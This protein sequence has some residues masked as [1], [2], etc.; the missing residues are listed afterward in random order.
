MSLTYTEIQKFLKEMELR[1]YPKL[2]IS[3]LRNITIEPI[4]P[5]LQ[6]LSYNMGYEAAI[7]FGDYDTV[8]NDAVG[9]NIQLLNNS[10]DCVLIFVKLEVLSSLLTYS[11]PSL[12]SEQIESEIT[13]IEGYINAVLKG[14]RQQTNAMI[15]WMGFDLPVNPALGIFDSQNDKGQSGTIHRLNGLVQKN[16]QC[17]E[18]TYFVD[19]NLS[20]ARIG[21]RKYFDHRYWHIGRAPFTKDALEDI[22]NESFKFIRALKGKSKKCLVVD[23]D[24]TLWA[25]VIGE[26]NLAGIKLSKSSHPGSSFYEFQ[27]EIVNLYHR[28]ILVA[29]CSKNNESDVW[30]VFNNHPD[31][32]LHPSHIATAQ[33]N[34]NDKASNIRQ[35]AKDLNIG[36][37]SLVFMD[38][39]EF[40]I[41][42]VRQLLPEVECVH[43]PASKS[44]SYRSILTSGGWFDNLLFTQED[45]N[46]GAMYKT[47]QQRSAA[48]LDFQSI[49]EYHQSLEMVVEINFA[50]SLSIPRIAQ[51]TQKTNQFNIT[52]KRYSDADIL[53][54]TKR[55]NADAVFLKLADKFGD[56]GIVGVCI[57]AYDD[58]KVTIDTF[59]L[60]CRVLGRKVENAFIL[61]I[62][63]LAKFRGCEIV[64]GEYLPT[65]KNLQVA[66]FYHNLGFTSID[67]SIS[68]GAIC[69]IIDNIDDHFHG[70]IL[71]NLVCQ[72]TK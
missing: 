13:R 61:K 20:V 52:S 70:K 16:I 21:V 49:E 40:E 68:E 46:R 4:T 1:K 9:G 56:Y 71:S 32:A 19:L 28:G 50:D 53:D 66:D 67:N 10:T 35:I 54:Y 31:M 24:N 18:H 3:I 72:I 42:L 39:S 14:I 51:L 45:K 36:L 41:N 43:L 29:L 30:D 59:L 44:T 25:G 12:S 26:D 37:D 22:A 6:Y 55:N 60:S 69:D 48:K 38:D 62:L 47:E 57:L 17:F 11:F 58:K 5:Y 7:N 64:S 23:C 15:L 34:W 33:I 63:E 2:N 65:E 27:Q 8:F